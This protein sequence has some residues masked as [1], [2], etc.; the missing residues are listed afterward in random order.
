MFV[1]PIT[2]LLV[3]DKTDLKRNVM[4]DIKPFKK[5]ILYLAAI[6]ILVSLIIPTIIWI[7]DFYTG[8]SNK[9]DSGRLSEF[10]IF[11]TFIISFWGLLFNVI[12][13]VIAYKAFKNF[14]VKKQ[15]Q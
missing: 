7:R 9:I 14:D 2:N 1:S 4:T 15:F 12:L 3:G 13:V 6:I 10:A 8:F 11:Q 5:I